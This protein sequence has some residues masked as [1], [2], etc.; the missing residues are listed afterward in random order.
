M[1][2]QKI[3][4]IIFERMCTRIINKY[5]Q[6]KNKRQKPQI[7]QSNAIKK[8]HKRNNRHKQNKQKHIL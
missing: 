4:I 7:S 5:R 8:Q 1:L 3:V 2:F 6:Q